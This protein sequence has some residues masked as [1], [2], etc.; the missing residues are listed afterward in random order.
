MR[1]QITTK[2]KI[3]KSAHEVFEAIV[4]PEKI[5]NY[6]FSSSSERWAQGKQITLRYDE[7]QAEGD[8]KV[9]EIIGNE[10]IV[11]SWGEETIVAI[12]LMESDN[13]STIIEVKESGFKEEDPELADK[14]IGQKEGWVYMLS[15]LKAY[16]ENGVTTLR[17]SL[18]H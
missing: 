17:A 5:G 3:L 11:F 16:L 9:I 15:C 10:R 12:T 2:L 13:G 8:I 7:Y 6:W 1:T 4:D 18:L 14:L